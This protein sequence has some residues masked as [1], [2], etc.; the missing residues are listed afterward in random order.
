MP[1]R[2]L[3]AALALTA[4]AACDSG[5][6]IDPPTPADVAGIY[7][8]GTLTFTPDATALGPVDVTDDLVLAESFVELLDSGQAVL[9]FRREGTGTT[10]R[11]VT[12]EFDVRRLELR[13]TFSA[14]NEAAL[15]R[16]LLPQVLT[17]T[18]SGDDALSLSIDRT[19]NLAAYDADRYSGFTAVDGTLAVALNRR[20]GS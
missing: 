19:A 20:S 12:G 15:G 5:P 14:G 11:L 6:A 9:R 2:L 8:I 17:F 10:T 18:R 16:V 13:V 3:L 7:D 1:L 4:V